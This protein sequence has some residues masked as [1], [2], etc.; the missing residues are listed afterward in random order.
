MATETWIKDAGTWRKG[1]EVW[2]KASGTWRQAQELWHKDSGTW[3]Q[4]FVGDDLPISVSINSPYSKTVSDTNSSWPQNA[5]ATWTVTENP[6]PPNNYT[7]AWTQTGGSGL[8]VVGGT[9]SDSLTLRYVNANPPFEDSVSASETWECKIT[10]NAGEV[11]S[12]ARTLTVIAENSG[13]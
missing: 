9:S 4:V 2:H 3:R 5:D 10:N 7:Y 6:V 8:S 12:V 1:V 11:T 13:S